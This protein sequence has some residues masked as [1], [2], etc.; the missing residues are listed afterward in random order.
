VPISQ[1]LLDQVGCANVTRHSP[2]SAAIRRLAFASNCFRIAFE[3]VML[4][5]RR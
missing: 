4:T 1:E 5:V 2:P 3:F